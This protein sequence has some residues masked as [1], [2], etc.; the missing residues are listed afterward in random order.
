M[1]ERTDVGMQAADAIKALITSGNLQPG[2]TLPTERDLANMLGISRPSLREAI[3]VLRAMNI[4]ESRHGDGTYVSSLEPH[5]LAQPIAFM[6][7][8]APTSIGYLFEVRLLMETDAAVLAAE[9]ITDDAVERLQTLIDEAK[10]VIDD[11]PHYT[12]VDHQFHTGIIEAA[13]NPI[14]TS[15]Y[16]SISELVL[17]ARRRTEVLHAT[18]EHSVHAH[19]TILDALRARDPERVAAEMR[20]HIHE[21]HEIWLATQEGSE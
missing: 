12:S 21:V 1:I 9:R 5:L 6:L 8:V 3:R 2:D 20:A 15:L 14:L 11:I 19:R 16:R 7:Q 17:E 13:A 10:H 18:R 4:V